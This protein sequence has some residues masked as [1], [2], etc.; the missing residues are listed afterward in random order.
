MSPVIL[1]VHRT[2]KN[3]QG[4][5]GHTRLHSDCERKGEPGK[6]MQGWKTRGGK[7]STMPSGLRGILAVL[8]GF[9]FQRWCKDVSQYSKQLEGKLPT[10]SLSWLLT[11]FIILIWKRPPPPP[12]PPVRKWRM[13][14]FL[15]FVW[16]SPGFLFWFHVIFAFCFPLT[17]IFRLFKHK[18]SFWN[19][20]LFLDF[21][22]VLLKSLPCFKCSYLT[23]LTSVNVSLC[24]PL[25]DK[26]VTP[27]TDSLVVFLLQALEK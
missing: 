3:K 20:N 21:P 24:L 15:L 6:W 19:S 4:P 13:H 1:W 17:H 25:K 9:H 23:V 27:P 8:T 5:A 18:F 2:F 12:K 16:P 14:H 22:N 26:N 11:G 7:N 10:P